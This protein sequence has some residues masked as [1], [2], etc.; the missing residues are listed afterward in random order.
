MLNFSTL[1]RYVSIIDSPDKRFGTQL[2]SLS[3]GRII[4]SL[5]ANANAIQA[6]TIGGRY[7]CI[8]RQFGMPGEPENAIFEYQM[9]SYKLISMLAKTI[10]MQIAAMK[11]NESWDL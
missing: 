5:Q 4:L 2:G 7:A 3:G 1:F 10:V 6:V 11:L 8:R 9:V